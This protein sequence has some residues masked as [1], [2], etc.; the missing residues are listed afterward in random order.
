MIP[1]IP[2]TPRR[3]G[4][5]DQILFLLP[6]RPK[7]KNQPE[8]FH[9]METKRSGT[10][11]KPHIFCGGSS[12][13]L[14]DLYW[15]PAQ[16]GSGSCLT[17]K[18]IKA[19]RNLKSTSRQN[20]TTTSWIRFFMRWKTTPQRLHTHTHTTITWIQLVWWFCRVFRGW[21][22]YHIGPNWRHLFCASNTDSIVMMKMW[23]SKK[24]LQRSTQSVGF[25][26]NGTPYPHFLPYHSHKNP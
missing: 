22:R 26:D 2:M 17:S 25:F 21:N 16:L 1:T 13:N 20:Q 4:Q 18:K 10:P 23:F 19:M 3:Q 8:S 5:N 15:S 14:P 9:D 11:K 7:L 12:K 24:N 6:H